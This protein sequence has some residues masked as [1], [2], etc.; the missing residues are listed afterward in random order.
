[1]ARNVHR[2]VGSERP[3]RQAESFVNPHVLVIQQNPS[4][5]GFLDDATIRSCLTHAGCLSLVAMDEC[6]IERVPPDSLKTSNASGFDLVI[7]EYQQPG[8]GDQSRFL[9][10]DVPVIMLVEE[11]DRRAAEASYGQSE[12]DLV[13]RTTDLETQLSDCLS[14]AT[15]RTS[16][17]RTNRELSRA[18]VAQRAMLPSEPPV[19]PGFDVAARID[20]ARVI[21]GDFFDYAATKDQKNCFIIGDVTGHGLNAALRMAEAQAYFRAFL[22]CPGEESVDPASVLHRV[23]GLLAASCA[24]MPLLATAMIVA[25][26]AESRSFVWAGAGHQGFLLRKAG[27]IEPLRSTG[28]VLGCVDEMEYSTIGPR[29]LEAGDAI[30]LPTDGIAETCSTRVKLFGRDR[31]LDCIRQ[32][33]GEPAADTLD[34]LFEQAQV[35]RGTTSQ[36]DDMTAILI[37]VLD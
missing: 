10:L 18:E 19:I 25:L 31:M 20:P 11:R 32:H 9:H 30:L 23:N 29:K 7:L 2:D 36:K 35:F 21:G 6:A 14:R 12:I 33:P 8:T 24:E 16:L 27:D 22:R 28:P 13:V 37:R 26:C 15:M 4:D 1:M 5:V 3:D 34:R 17:L